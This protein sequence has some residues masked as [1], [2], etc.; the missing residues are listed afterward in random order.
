MQRAHT[1]WRRLDDKNDTKLLSV[2]F[3]FLGMFLVDRSE[4]THNI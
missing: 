4:L 1:F 2:F 3:P